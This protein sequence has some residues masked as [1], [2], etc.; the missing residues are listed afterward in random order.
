[1][2][3]RTGSHRAASSCLAVL[4]MVAVAGCGSET[5]SSSD[6]SGPTDDERFD[7]SSAKLTDQPFCDELDLTLIAEVL[8]LS[9]ANV[10]L[11]EDREVGEKF[12]GPNE[13]AAPPASTANLCVLGSTSK[14]FL[15]S[16]QPDASASD[17]QDTLDELAT[18]SGDE[19]SETCEP[20]DVS[21]FGDPGGAYTC[22][23]GPPLER[24]RVVATGLVGGSKFFCSVMLNEGAGPELATTTLDACRTTLEE[25]AES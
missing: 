4:T 21:D 15:V 9:G 5:S 6:G 12:E 10:K 14:Q 3:R 2:L 22:S 17:V 8:G 18:L 1:M 7:V 19:S 25:L 13:E 16:V 23:S 11:R 24:V 20:T